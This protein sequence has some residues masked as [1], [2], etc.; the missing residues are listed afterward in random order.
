MLPDATSGL[1]TWAG[2]VQEA[3]GQSG[4]FPVAPTVA[5]VFFFFLCMLEAITGQI[6]GHSGHSH[7]DLENGY[8]SMDQQVSATAIAL[9]VS[10]SLHSVLEGAGIGAQSSVASMGLVVAAVLAHKGL[11]LFAM[12]SALVKSNASPRLCSMLVAM[13]A[14]CTP[15]GIMLGIEAQGMFGKAGQGLVLA[16]AA[17]TFLYVAIPELLVPTF[18]ESKNKVAA[19]SLS[20]IGFL[21]MAALAA[22]S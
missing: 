22:W 6:L 1:K 17:G 13:V 4:E 16:A 20:Y 8:T 19:V 10:L 2:S 3:L 7:G 11:A 21:S 9:V 12:T 15:L 14:S 5:G 18:A